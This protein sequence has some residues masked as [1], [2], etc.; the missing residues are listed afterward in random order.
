[1]GAEIFYLFRPSV[2]PRHMD[3]SPAHWR[4]SLNFA[5]ERP[6]SSVPESGESGH[7]FP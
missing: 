5:A 2:N 1:M 4:F 3:T 7:R 6:V